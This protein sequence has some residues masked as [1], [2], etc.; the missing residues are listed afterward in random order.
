MLL[1]DAVCRISRLSGTG[2]RG[3][4]SL[5]ACRGEKTRRLHEAVHKCLW[6][7]HVAK[8]AD[9]IEGLA[10]DLEFIRVS[11]I[12]E[13]AYPLLSLKDAARLPEVMV[14][15]VFLREQSS[16]PRLVQQRPPG[17]LTAGIRPDPIFG[18]I[19]HASGHHRS[20]RIA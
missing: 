6:R 8:R 19:P 17:T 16:R 2:L 18:G 20:R 4:Q 13:V 1:R 12:M 5:I 3:D 10:R 15:E 7:R 14:D 11:D 9:A